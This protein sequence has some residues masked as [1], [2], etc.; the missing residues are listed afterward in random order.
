LRLERWARLLRHLRHRPDGTAPDASRQG[1]R[2]PRCAGVQTPFSSRE[3][4][5]RRF[6]ARP[7]HAGNVWRLGSGV[8]G[9][10]HFFF[11][12]ESR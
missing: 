4:A 5:A 10:R 7:I 3:Q 2:P 8:N 12:N 1:A 11:F 6:A 9:P